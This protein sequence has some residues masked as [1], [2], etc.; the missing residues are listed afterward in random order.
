[1]SQRYICPECGNQDREQILDNDLPV[2]D[3]GFALLCMAKL[4]PSNAFCG[5]EWSPNEA[6]DD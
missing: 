5:M 4:P 1:M 2:R 6:D 3:P